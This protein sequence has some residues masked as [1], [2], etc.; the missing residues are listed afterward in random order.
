VGTTTPTSEGLPDLVTPY[1][2]SEF[3]EV[4]D[5][6][7]RYHH[8]T[9]DRYITVAAEL[10]RMLGKVKGTAVL[11][12]VDSKIAAGRVTRHLVRAGTFE[13]AAARAVVRS[14]QTYLELFTG[15]SAAAR[16]REFDPDK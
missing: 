3:H 9:M 14:Y 5:A 6:C 11:L 4:A 13:Q 15:K 12:G 16:A 8:A 10:R 7:R 2:T 1:N